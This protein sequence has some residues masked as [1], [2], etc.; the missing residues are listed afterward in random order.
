MP[1]TTVTSTNRIFQETA[2][3]IGSTQAALNDVRRQI[4]SGLKHESYSTMVGDVSRYAGLN[5]ALSRI[6][7]YI[8][9]INRVIPRVQATDTALDQLINIA[10]SLRDNIVLKQTPSGADLEID[11]IADGNLED[12]ENILN[13][14]V[15]THRIFSGSKTDSDP[16][17]ANTNQVQNYT[18]SDTV[19][20]S[21]NAG[22]YT[23][24]GASLQL[25]VSDGRK[26]GY[27]ITGDN[28]AFQALISAVHLAKEIDTSGDPDI[29]SRA[30][31]Q[32][33]TAISQLSS[34]R[35]QN[36]NVLDTIE[37]ARDTHELAKLS[38][39]EQRAAIDETDILEA[40][41]KAAAAE[42]TLQA[43]FQVFARI[44]NLRL[45]DFI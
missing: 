38:L 44:T 19:P 45:I 7:S 5:D 36:A 1:N 43:T 30:M 34:L 32:I 33:N 23:G 35:G 14:K 27:N 21:V 2:G 28:A 8:N 26:I 6:E 9:S 12:I 24:D 31:D 39:S 18:S 10:G 17:R 4:S 15:G 40:S 20:E 22:Y 29:I 41:I 3:Y 42:T 16:I 11:V 37:N 13:T 25:Q